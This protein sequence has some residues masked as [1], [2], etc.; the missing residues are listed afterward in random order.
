MYEGLFKYI[1]EILKEKGNFKLAVDLG[2][3]YCNYASVIKKYASYLIGVDKDEYRLKVALENGCDEVIKADIR[4]YE[5]PKDVDLIT[6]FDV[7][8]HLPKMDGIK[9]LKRL[10]SYNALII[11]T[12]PSR[13]FPLAVNHHVSLWTVEELKSLGYEVKLI[14]PSLFLSIFY[15][16]TILAYKDNRVKGKIL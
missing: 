11:L 5:L 10:D 2:C 6:L 1:E 4:E 16:K 9:L 8:E 14:E 13:F 12:T 3:G 7:I 15:G